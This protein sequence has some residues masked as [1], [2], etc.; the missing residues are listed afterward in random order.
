MQ[1]LV[2]EPGDVFDDG[3]LQLRARAPG[4]VGDQLGLEGVDE[5]L[6]HR[7][8]KRIADRSDRGEDAGVI[9]LLGVVGRRILRAAVGVG[10]ELEVGAMLALAEGHAQGVEDEVGAHVGGQLPADDLAGEGVE[11]EGEVADAL[12]GAQVGEVA[13]PEPV[14]P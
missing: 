4:A 10:H 3:Q 8:V 7:V 2:V 12:P 5:A 11:D 13:D 9:E 6:G 14:G 1:A